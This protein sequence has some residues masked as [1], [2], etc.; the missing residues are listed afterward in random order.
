MRWGKTV[1]L[2]GFP[3]QSLPFTA[4]LDNKP[5]LKTVVPSM[6]ILPPEGQD[7]IVTADITGL[8]NGT[9]TGT[10]T[11]S[12][13]YHF[14]VM[15]SNAQGCSGT[16]DYEIDIAPLPPCPALTL[17]PLTLPPATAGVAVTVQV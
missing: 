4:T 14:T 1:V 8:P 12:G 11:Q 13:P 17:Q 9:F 3:G 15:A 7:F 10:P 6:G 16:R 2:S 5:W